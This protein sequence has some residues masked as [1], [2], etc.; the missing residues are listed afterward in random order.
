M[1]GELYDD[2][3]LSGQIDVLALIQGK[4]FVIECKDNPFKFNA[5][6]V[7]NELNKFRKVNKGSYQYKL[8]NKIQ[9]VVNNWDSVMNYLGV[10]DP[11]T[12]A[13]VTGRAQ[14]V[15]ELVKLGELKI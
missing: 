3:V 5:K 7:G 4:L 8:K 10:L 15:V 14:A 9:D 1:L 6:A 11:N 13:N 2:V 12:A